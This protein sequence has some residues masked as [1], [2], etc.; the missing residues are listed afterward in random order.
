ML[1]KI[2]LRSPFYIKATPTFGTF[3][4]AEI[5]LYIYTGIY[6]TDKPASPQY[7]I[8]K[9]AIGSDNYATF[10]IAELVRDYLDVSFNQEFTE[11]EYITRVLDDGG[12][13]EG[14]PCLS[15]I[16]DTFDDDFRSQTVWVESDITVT[17]SYIGG[18]Y[19]ETFNT[20]YLAFD[21][22][23]YYTDGANP[24]LSRTLL[25]S[26]TDIYVESGKRVQ[27]PVYTDVVDFV[28]FYSNG[29]LQ[30]RITI[31]SSLNSNAQIKY[32]GTTATVDEIRVLSGSDTETINVYQLDECKF[33]PYK[34]TFVNKFGALQNIYFFKKSIQSINTTTET[35]RASVFNRESLMYDIQDHQY[36]EFSKQGRE[37]ITMN[38]GFISQEYNEVIKQLMLSEQVWVTQEVD[39]VSTILPMNLKSQSLQYKTRVNDKLIDYTLDFDY[40]FDKINTIR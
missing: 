28:E 1:Q 29:V 27:V 16:L 31:S 6:V 23:G 33:T 39:G 40:S 10:E 22:Y 21:G 34:V 3:I 19:T 25:Q 37:S 15:A 12:V 11:D 35:Y 20:N 32:A 13:F 17:Y 5:K 9:S 24:E 4:S 8:T 2:N 18:E 36:R 7:T 26:N 38:T 14:S 30:S